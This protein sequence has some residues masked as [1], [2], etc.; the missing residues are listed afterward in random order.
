MF[1][2]TLLPWPHLEQMF[3]VGTASAPQFEQNIWELKELDAAMLDSSPTAFA[4]T[5][6]AQDPFLWFW[7]CR[8]LFAFAVS[9]LLLSWAFCFCRECFCFVVSFCFCRELLLLPWIF[10]FA[11]SFLLSPW[12]FYFAVSF[13]LLPRGFW[14]A[15][16]FLVLPWAFWFCRE[17]FVIA[18]SILVL[19][20]RIWFRRD[21]FGFAVRYLLL[22]WQLWATVQTNHMV[23]WNA[24]CEDIFSV[25]SRLFLL[26]VVHS[27]HAYRQEESLSGIS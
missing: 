25:V 18:V 27:Q 13:L 23:H 12:V 20:W 14:F 19:P 24:P 4:C 26:R 7:F 9:F 8:E 5:I 17:E 21:I 11:V 22:P 15:L 3:A 6:R 1:I 10:A 16:S 2:L